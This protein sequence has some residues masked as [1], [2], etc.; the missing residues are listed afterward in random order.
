MND[1]F[2]YA[3]E[4][5][6]QLVADPILIPQS[7]NAEMLRWA[8][9]CTAS[10]EWFCE[11]YNVPCPSWVH[12]FTYCLPEPWFDSP[13]EYKSEVRKRLIRE[14]PEQFTKRNIYCGNRMFANKWELVRQHR[15]LVASICLTHSASLDANLAS[16]SLPLL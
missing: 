10:V 14:T 5:R 1:W 15:Q 8:T 13:G 6:P 11:R 7:A 9:F 3:K 4:K 16:S 2:D 12:A